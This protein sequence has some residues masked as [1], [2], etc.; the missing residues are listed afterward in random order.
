M[1]AQDAPEKPALC[2]CDRFLHVESACPNE[3]ADHGTVVSSPALCVRCMFY[4]WNDDD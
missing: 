3:P 1:T 4:C 2:E